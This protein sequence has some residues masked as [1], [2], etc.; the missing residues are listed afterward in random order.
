MR[1]FLF[2]WPACLQPL[3]LAW[4][5]CIYDVAGYLYASSAACL[6][7]TNPKRASKQPVAASERNRP[8]LVMLSLG[9]SDPSAK[10]EARVENFDISKTGVS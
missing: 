9:R 2:K 5:P 10:A 3:L 7:R 6:P 1:P 8:H 4:K